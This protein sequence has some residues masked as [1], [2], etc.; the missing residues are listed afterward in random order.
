MSPDTV[1]QDQ[2]IAFVRRIERPVDRLEYVMRRLDK[3][4][5]ISPRT[6]SCAFFLASR[7]L[8]TDYE[9]TKRICR[10]AQLADA[11]GMLDEI[12]PLADRIVGFVYLARMDGVADRVNIGFTSNIAK[13]EAALS[14]IYGKRVEILDT[15]PGTILDE[16]VAHCVNRASRLEG[17]WFSVGKAA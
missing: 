9:T 15:V 11:S 1:A 8:R 13:R 5:G 6:M 16:H 14:R 7:V 17:E 2:L 4:R 10:L 12:G 3:C